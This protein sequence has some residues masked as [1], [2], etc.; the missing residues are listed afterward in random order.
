MREAVQ[1]RL[2]VRMVADPDLRAARR[3]AVGVEDEAGHGRAALQ[4]EVLRDVR[5]GRRHG[6][7]ARREVGVADEEPD[8]LLLRIDAGEF[9]A[10]VAAGR[11]AAEPRVPRRD[12]CTG[13][14]RPARV[15]HATGDRA[16]GPQP[17]VHR[18][19]LVARAA[20]DVDELLH[21]RRGRAPSR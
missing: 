21:P 9:V 16:A 7:G 1:R 11:R 12:L 4:H 5:A 19:R 3:P 20:A 8:L 6:G 18:H 15:G 17:E 14:R 13:D 2:H 10:A